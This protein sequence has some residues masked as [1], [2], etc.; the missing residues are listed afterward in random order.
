LAPLTRTGGL[1]VQLF[2]V[3]SGFLITYLLI[4]EVEQKGT[5]DI[6]R[7]YKRRALRI[8]PL[9]F[10]CMIMGAIILPRIMSAFTY[11]GNIFLGLTFLN[12]YD[13][14]Y[15]FSQCP[16]AQLGLSWSV[17]IEEQFYL[18]WPLLFGLLIK[19]GNSY[20][21]FWCL[22]LIAISIFFA[23]YTTG[24]VRYYHTVSNMGYLITGCFGAF[25]I[26]KNPLSSILNI[27]RKR[28]WLIVLVTILTTSFRYYFSWFYLPQLILS[29]FLYLAIILYFSFCLKSPVNIFDKLGKYTYGM[30][31]YHTMVLTAIFVLFDI[32]KLNYNQNNMVMF[33]AAILTLPATILIS[34]V[35]YNFLESPFL[36]LKK[37][38][39]VV[40]TR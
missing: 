7:F 36:K 4:S 2:F 3:I 28:I 14:I 25:Y 13:V 6:I 17:A 38:L 19:I 39:A 33:C 12:N 35:S 18:F 22:F 26:K 27:I 34:I 20:R 37:K 23:S 16:G 21:Y 15:N 5:V 32:L 1:G 30:Y 8:W 31:F 29:P 11:C 40:Q 10:F 9:Y 24:D